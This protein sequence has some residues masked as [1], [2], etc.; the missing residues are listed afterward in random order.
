M[1]TQT[2]A[3]A[4]TTAL[5]RLPLLSFADGRIVLGSLADFNAKTPA[6][7]VW[8]ENKAPMPKDRNYLGLISGRCLRTFKGGRCEVIGA[9][10]GS[11]LP[12]LDALNATVPQDEWPFKYGS[13]TEREPAWKYVYRLYMLDTQDLR[14]V[15]F[16]NSTF[17]AKRAVHD[18]ED[19][20]NWARALF[21]ATDVMPMLKLSEAVMHSNSWGEIRRPAFEIT[22]WRTFGG[23]ALRTVDAHALALGS[24]QPRPPTETLADEIPY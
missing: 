17:G 5:T 21:G 14:I 8:N 4:Q 13:S 2:T 20:W 3:V 1:S 12:D 23:G 24:P 16:L 19:R 18:V 7:W 15:S 10:I 22:G 11:E 6:G 9:E